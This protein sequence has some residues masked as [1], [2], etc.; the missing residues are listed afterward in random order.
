M[1][2]FLLCTFLIGITLLIVKL[3]LIGKGKSDRHYSWLEI[4]DRKKK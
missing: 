2:I 3:S 1:F 4:V